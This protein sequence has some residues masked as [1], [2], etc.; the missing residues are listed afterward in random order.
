MI[1]PDRQVERILAVKTHALGDVLM[2]TPAIRVLRKRFP[3]AELDFL[4]GK[5]SEP[6]IRFNPHINR[7]HCVPDEVFFRRKIV[8]LLRL[9]RWIKKQK[10]ELA[11]LF[12]PSPA[13]RR[14]ITHCGINR[15][16][17]LYTGGIPSGLTDPVPWRRSRDRYVG[18]DFLDVVRALG[19]EDDSNGMEYH[20]PGEVA[21]VMQKWI[22]QTFG[23]DPSY[24]LIC[25]GGGSNPRDTVVQKIWPPRRSGFIASQLVNRGIG[26]V[27]AGLEN[28]RR[29]LRPVFSVNGVV[30]MIGKTSIAELAFLISR[31]R[32]VLT[33]DSLP[34]HLSLALKCPVIAVFGP[35]RSRSVIPPGSPAVAVEPTVECAPCYDNEPFPGCRKQDCIKS[36]SVDRVWERVVEALQGRAE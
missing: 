18:E 2:V 27:I 9:M 1:H 3:G 29:F 31:S 7:I 12:Q 8:Y 30:D 5:W 28:E 19:A 36:I 22:E 25:P 17:G 15:I 24:V 33:N 10:Y 32:F 16:A 4:V 21:A 35:T 34:L 23:R 13:L 6:A 26:V 20:V 11:V 14:I